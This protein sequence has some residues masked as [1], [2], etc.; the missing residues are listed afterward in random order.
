MMTV[1]VASLGLLLW[2]ASS[3]SAQID[4]CS[5]P[6]DYPFPFKASGL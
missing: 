5:L 6:G 4:L 3:V 2:F 1:K